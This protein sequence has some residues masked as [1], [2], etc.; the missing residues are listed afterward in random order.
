MIFK[1]ICADP[2]LREAQ[3]YLVNCFCNLK[4][5]IVFKHDINRAA[6]IELH[7]SYIGGREKGVGEGNGAPATCRGFLL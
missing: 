3:N 1:Q 2:I 7:R 4:S 6:T 5:I